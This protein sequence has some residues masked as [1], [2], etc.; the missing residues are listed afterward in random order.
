MSESDAKKEITSTGKG[1]VLLLIVVFLKYGYLFL[2]IG[3]AVHF[4]R[5]LQLMRKVRLMKEDMR[6][7]PE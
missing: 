7:I 2:R 6:Q 3:L 1:L 4:F 5:I